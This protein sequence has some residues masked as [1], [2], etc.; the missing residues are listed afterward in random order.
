MAAD[1]RE[2]LRLI[3]EGLFDGNE[4]Y[5]ASSSSSRGDGE[6]VEKL[7]TQWLAEL[8]APELLPFPAELVDELKQRIE[9]QT[10]LLDSTSSERR[11]DSVFKNIARQELDR[12]QYLIR[13]FLRARLAKVHKYALFYT[14]ADTR[15]SRLSPAETEFAMNFC[16]LQLNHFVASGLKLLDA[17]HQKIDAK[18]GMISKPNVDTHVFCR[19]LEDIGEF[20]IEE[21]VSIDL[22]EGDIW[23]LRYS[24][25]EMLLLE[26]R[27]VLI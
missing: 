10:T 2:A 27:A 25:I 15:R 19:I 16:E 5:Q 21:N 26:G 23:V 8:V 4:E 18:A 20:E 3:N 24:A 11:E 9:D 1:D 6:L 13:S 12:L 14:R 7:R 17:D 22:G